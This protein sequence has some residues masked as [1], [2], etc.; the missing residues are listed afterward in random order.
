MQG[1]GQDISGMNINVADLPTIICRC[2]SV[3]WF[4]TTILKEVSALVSP[5]GQEGVI[6]VPAD[7]FCVKCKASLTEVA[8]E[9]EEA[10]DGPKSESSIIT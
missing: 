2:G 5:N 10:I 3:L 7:M 6:P 8:K 9:Q 1:Q 4:Q